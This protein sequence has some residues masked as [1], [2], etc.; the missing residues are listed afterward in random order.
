MNGDV[1]TLSLEMNINLFNR[2]KIMI[3]IKNSTVLV[4]LSFL[5]T[6]NTPSFASF[7]TVSADSKCPC[8]HVHDEKQRE[9][10]CPCTHMKPVQADLN[11]TPEQQQKIKSIRKKAALTFRTNHQKIRVIRQQINKLSQTD[12]LDEKKLDKLVMEEKELIAADIKLKAIMRH[13][14]YNVLNAKQ[15]QQLIEH[16]QTMEINSQQQINSNP[17]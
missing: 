4:I 2:R 1:Y 17:S 7:E 6:L 16:I 9:R 15:K 8:K 11:L 10:N 12:K 14:I 13:Q 5:L 3:T